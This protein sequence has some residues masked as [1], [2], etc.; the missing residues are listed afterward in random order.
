MASRRIKRR[1][2]KKRTEGVDITS[3]LDILTILL[4]FLV[5]SYNSSG[6]V[7]NIPEGI[8]IPHSESITPNTEG[9]IV[10]VSKEKIW[11][12]DV[13]VFDTQKLPDMAYD[14]DG[15]R[16]IPLYDELMKKKEIFNSVSKAAG[17]QVKPFQ[18][19]VNL[20]VDKSI[21]YSF[22]KK[23]MYTCGQAGFKEFK[24]VV[25]GD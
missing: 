3:L 5:Q 15:Y 21:K 6:I 16:I 14:E 19:V 2:N 22:V 12:D 8:E 11:V 13:E 10:Q 4:V 23:L 25:M 17:G 1:G 20:V 7:V 9:V 24:F 18:G